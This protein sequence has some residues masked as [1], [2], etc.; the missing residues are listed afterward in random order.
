MSERQWVNKKCELQFHREEAES[1][2]PKAMVARGNAGKA[3]RVPWKGGGKEREASE[4][5]TGSVR[6]LP[7]QVALVRN[8]RQFDLKKKKK[9]KESV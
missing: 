5:V 1:P 6:P 3:V 2:T 7:K 9:K 4:W 8:S